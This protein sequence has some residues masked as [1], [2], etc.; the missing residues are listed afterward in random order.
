MVAPSTPRLGPTCSPTR[1]NGLVQAAAPTSRPV[2]RRTGVGCRW[3]AKRV[4]RTTSIGTCMRGR[5]SAYT[6]PSASRVMPPRARVDI[7][8]RSA[9]NSS[10]AEANSSTVSP[11]RVSIA[12]EIRWVCSSRAS[13]S[14]YA[15]GAPIV[16]HNLAPRT[17]D[18]HDGQASTALLGEHSRRFQGSLGLRRAVERDHRM[19][20]SL[21]LA[22]L[23]TS[24]DEQD[25]YICRSHHVICD[26]P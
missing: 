3:R 21:V 17:D 4:E 12:T 10:V 13:F 8:M 7:T 18:A 25:R 15:R 14:R 22:G 20:E 5:M 19:R 16:T 26:T 1:S 24:W 6:L 9:S 11:Y 2:L 23:G